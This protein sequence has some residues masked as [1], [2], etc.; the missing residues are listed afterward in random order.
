MSE[1]SKRGHDGHEWIP[2][3]DFC[4]HCG[5]RNLEAFGTLCGEPL[6]QV[7]P[8]KPRTFA[9]LADDLSAYQETLELVEVKLAQPQSIDGIFDLTDERREI[10]NHLERIGKELSTKTDACAGVIRR[11]DADR[12]EIIAEIKRL[13]AKRKAAERASDWLKGYILSTMKQTGL[14]RLK[15]A[16]NTITVAKN[17]GRQ[18]LTIPYPELVPDDL[19]WFRMANLSHGNYQDLVTALSTSGMITLR[20]VVLQYSERIPNNEA[21]RAKIEAGETV[22]GAK[23]EPRSERLDVR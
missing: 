14:Q 6:A 22:P 2:G 1:L 23:L 13:T 10:I 21:I 3:G 4:I 16:T 12:D 17:G 8:V 15:T 19:C 20:E 11:L 9:E 5:L 7:A 18:A